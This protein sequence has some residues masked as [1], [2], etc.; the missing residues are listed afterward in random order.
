MGSNPTFSTKI[1][2]EVRPFCVQNDPAPTLFKIFRENWPGINVFCHVSYEVDQA[3]ETED[4]RYDFTPDPNAP[5]HLFPS[6]HCRPNSDGV[7]YIELN[8]G[9]PLFAV[10][11][12]LA[13][14]LAHA[15]EGPTQDNCDHGPKWGA[16]FNLLLLSAAREWG[17]PTEGIDPYREF[18]YRMEVRYNDQD[19]ED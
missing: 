8:A 14:E 15:A 9:I 12:I 10:A 4:G 6:G 3:R 19:D 17:M 1:C 7:A 16:R 11:E 5:V 2:P 13:H 18:L